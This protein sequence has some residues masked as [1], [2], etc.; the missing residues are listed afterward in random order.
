MS[1]ACKILAIDGG[2]I[3]GIIPAY[4]LQQIEAALGK[5]IYQCFD[6]IAGTSTGGLIAMALT[7]PISSNHNT[8][9]SASSILDLYMTDESQIFVCQS[10]GDFWESKYYGISQ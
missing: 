9:L 10:T 4:I 8:P 7:T 5:P 3:R 1:Y 6:I 2:G